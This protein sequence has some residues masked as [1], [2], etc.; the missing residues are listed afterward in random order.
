MKILMINSNK[1]QKK[2]FEDFFRNADICCANVDENIVKILNKNRFH[3]ILFTIQTF[4]DFYLV[5]YIKK[6]FPESKLV[7]SLQDEM[8]ELVSIIQD[9]QFLTTQNPISLKKLKKIM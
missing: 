1:W 4:S 8:S 7:I 5:Q 3:S 6:N 2:E 9:G